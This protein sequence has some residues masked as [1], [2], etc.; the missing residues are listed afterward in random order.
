MSCMP[1]LFSSCSRSR[2]GL[3]AVIL[4]TGCGGSPAQSGVAADR[5]VPAV[6]PRT[7]VL[8]D[9][10]EALRAYCTS[11]EG[12]A[13][14]A[15]IKSDFDR[16][17]L[18]FPF[19]DEP[20]TYGD[21]EPNV[22][23]SDKADKWR[24]AQD[25]CGRVSGVAEA[26]TL[27][28][29]VT[30][31]DKYLAK[32]KAFLLASCEWGF[33]P[34]W[35]SGSVVGATDIYYNDE[36]HFR[37]WRKLPLVYDQ[38][39]DE[40]T[41]GEREVV[42]ASFKTRGD[43]SVEWIRS[44]E[45]DKLKRNSIEVKPR[46]HPVRFM[47]MTGLTGL[48]LWD[49]LPEAREWWRFAYG[50]YRDQ[51]SPWGGDDGGWA[52]GNAYWR[53]T[54]EH[55]GFQDA[56]LAIG[57]PL[58]YASPFWKNSPFF[59][60]YNVQPY[61]HTTFGD[62]SNAG[63]FNLEPVIADF[64]EH[65]ARV[66]QNGLFLTYAGLCTDSRT[67]PV[68]KGLTGLDRTYPTACEFLIRNFIASKD[69][70][71]AAQPLS[72][73]PPYRFFRDV[74]WVSMHSALGQ[75]GED[76]H[77]TFKSSP[78]GS[79]S[80]SHADQN[81]FILNAFGEGLAINSAYREFHR[82]PHHTDWTW[83]TR[84]KNA[85]L[86]DGLGQKAQDKTATGKIT[87][88]EVG[89]RYVW[90][91]GDATV[92]YRTLQPEGRVERVTRDLVFIDQRYVVLRDRV[93]LTT[94]GKLSWLLHAE[95]DLSW[96]AADNLA[97]IRGRNATLTA[98]LIAPEVTWQGKVTDRFPVP[99]DPKY[100]SGEAGASYVTGEW[101][102]QS[103]L[104]LESTAAATEFTVYSVLWPDRAVVRSPETTLVDASTLRVSR[105]DGKRDFIRLT[106]LACELSETAPSAEAAADATK[107]AAATPSP[108][109]ASGVPPAAEMTPLSFPDAE[110]FVYAGR[111]AESMRLHVMKPKDWKAGD[112]RP[113]MVF[114][115]GGGWTK[116]TPAKSISWA[117]YAARL[118]MVGIAPDYRT[119]NR[120]G[121]SPLESVADGR[122]AVRWIGDH[123]G[124]LGIDPHKIVVGGSS[125]GGHVA[126][127]TA[128]SKPPPGS[129]AAESPSIKPAALILF[130]AVSD[131]S[132][133]TGYTPQRFGT[134]TLPLSPVHHLDPVMPPMLVFHGDADPLVPC[135]QA[136]AL[137]DT[138]VGAGN[139][140]ELVLVPGGNHGFTS[141]FP[142]WKE[143]SRSR[144]I[145]FLSS[146]RLLPPDEP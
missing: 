1:P 107:T 17:F 97:L 112:L 61:L 91:T 115:F 122:A 85:L 108:S 131:T 133:A 58:A 33:D 30:G 48:A 57:D 129:S 78:Y 117:K 118:G 105:P 87:R 59:A 100:V 86:I 123:S 102:D 81:A 110:T 72:G 37:L 60:L 143:K 67:R 55:A 34:D 137:H 68:D 66:Q 63:R 96:N 130:S 16:D 35:R 56:L 47:A 121:T 19:P 24:A 82:S 98:Q 111:G 14:F 93:V 103:H 27:I 41:S 2:L 38:L 104:T 52:E 21:P 44:A 144:V 106:D 142:E 140:C 8:P 53:G 64:M 11:G 43:R 99:V 70:L 62:V 32:A 138:L 76:I 54:F 22:R 71:P 7:M 75:P 25:V 49:D 28:W 145:D 45:I 20:M 132:A 84:S 13:G 26:A 4:L 135:Q 134:N 15:K 88:F 40:L 9:R 94:P 65:M 69:P 127:W 125:A 46:S 116:G 89:D 80:H 101:S 29:R 146:Q 124:E 23:D 119:K 136:I 128:I 39:R 95:K 109:A 139:T 126:L 5:Y 77:I 10:Q 18:D 6:A 83:Q 141:Q 36:A 92:A 31:E 3:V 50:F 73:L 113:A 51:F 12:R 74:G 79:F 114:F 90:T 120:F 42:L